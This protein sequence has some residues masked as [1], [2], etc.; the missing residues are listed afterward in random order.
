M[1]ARAKKAARSLFAA[2][3]SGDATNAQIDEVAAL[4]EVDSYRVEGWYVEYCET[5]A[6][7]NAE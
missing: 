4:W 6:E 3:P 1:D 7:R 2:A 5:Y